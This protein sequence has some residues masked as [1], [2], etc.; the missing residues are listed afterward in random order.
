MNH[1]D[2][3]PVSRGARGWPRATPA[4]RTTPF[5]RLIA[6]GPEPASCLNRGVTAGYSSTATETAGLKVRAQLAELLK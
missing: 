3:L 4:L 6:A 2:A 5:R 1:L